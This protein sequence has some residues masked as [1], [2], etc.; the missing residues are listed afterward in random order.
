M[1][2]LIVDDESKTDLI[3]RLNIKLQ[4]QTFIQTLTCHSTQQALE[5]IREYQPDVIILDLMF[6]DKEMEFGGPETAR[7]LKEENWAGIII[8]YSSDAIKTQQKDYE[9]Y[10]DLVKYFVTKDAAIVGHLVSII[11]EI[12]QK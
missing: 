1:K 7:Q 9:N 2:I 6:S 10:G 4:N 12:T 3:E 11:G 5:I 8:S